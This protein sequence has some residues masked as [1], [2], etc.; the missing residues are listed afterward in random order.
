MTGWKHPAPEGWSDLVWTA[1]EEDIGTGDVSAS[2]LNPE[3]VVEWEI[4]CQAEGILCGCGIANYLLQ[5]ESED[6]DEC[7]TSV[8][9]EDGEPV[10]KGDVVLKGRSLAT[11]LLA[12]ERTAL[13]FLMM[14]SGVASTTKKYAEKLEGLDCHVTDTR[15]TVPGMRSL[16]KYAVRCGGGKNHRFGLYDAVMVK[17]NHI[18]AAG[19]I[20]EAVARVRHGIGHMTRIEVECE[21]IDQVRE[22]VLA[23]VDVILLD[24]MDPFTMAEATKEFRDRVIFEASGGINLDTV[25]GAAASG[26]HVVSVGALTH[27]APALPF[28]LEVL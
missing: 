5:P 18:R 25:R 17:D 27:S 23:G 21:D 4:E 26:V 16:Q 6:P 10:Q 8:Q 22:A 3:S 13:N 20:T 1:L 11:R 24:N 15:K 2:C 14:L 9:F 12:R 19:S 28:H 7:Q